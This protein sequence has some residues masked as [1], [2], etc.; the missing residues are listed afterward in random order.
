MSSRGDEKIEAYCDSDWASCPM[1]RR[2]VSGFCIKLGTSLISWKAK[3]QNT[4]SRSSAEAEY[5]CMAQ[6]VAKLTWLKGLLQELQV[7]VQLPINLYCDN[8]AALQIAANPMYHER[9]KHIEIDC[10][11]IREKLQEGLVRTN[12]VAS[13]EQPADV[14]TKALGRQQHAALLVKLGMKN[15]FHSQLE[16]ECRNKGIVS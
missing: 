7:K 1:S 4:I 16:G 13:K 8:K 11:F 15:I 14:F 3:K 6:T 12:Y 5:R 9:T 10:H 2:S